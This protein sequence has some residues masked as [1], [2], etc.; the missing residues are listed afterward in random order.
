[1]SVDKLNQTDVCVLM[2]LTVGAVTYYYSDRTVYIAN[3]NDPATGVFQL[4]LNRISSIGAISSSLDLDNGSSQVGNLSVALANPDKLQNIFLPDS[5]IE[6][7]VYFC[8]NEDFASSFLVFNGIMRN[9]QSDESSFSFDIVDYG[10][11]PTV[12]GVVPQYFPELKIKRESF[13]TDWIS[14]IVDS[15]PDD[16]S[17]TD[18]ALVQADQF[19][20]GQI[21]YIVSGIGSSQGRGI[22]NFANKK[23]TVDIPFSPALS[24][25]D[26]QFIITKYGIPEKSDAVGKVYPLP[27]GRVDRMLCPWIAGTRDGMADK[28][29][30]AGCEV[31]SCQGIFFDD[32]DDDVIDLAKW[33]LTIAAGTITESGDIYISQVFSPIT[34]R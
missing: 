32:F 23:I 26:S 14:G 24:T 18:S 3:R 12:T 21:V 8:Y 16:I 22:T 28:Y 10:E 15:L 9:E 11:M 6:V 17:F 13:A 20:A 4:Y 5:E 19:W 30:L 25:I 1:M 27:F 31:K 29:L 2:E 33:D 7:T 34:R